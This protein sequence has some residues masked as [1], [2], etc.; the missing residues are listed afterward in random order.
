VTPDRIAAFL[1]T[2]RF[3]RDRTYIPV[4]AMQIRL[5][6]APTI[7]ADGVRSTPRGRK[8]WAVLAYVLLAE[9]PPSRQ[10]L[11]SLLFAEADDPLGALRWTLAE[12][13]RTLRPHAEIEGDPVTIRFASPDTVTVDVLSSLATAAVDAAGADAEV[14]DLPEGE[15]LD[16]I[17]FEGCDAFETWLLVERR[18][19]AATV[20]GAL[21]E[22]ALHLLATGQVAKATAVASRLVSLNPL[23]ENFQEL[24]VRC[25]ATSGQREAAIQQA[26]NCAELFGRELGM[27]PSPAV[28]R[29]AEAG[30]G[31]LSPGPTVGRA[32]ARAQ[33]EAGQAAISAGAVDAGIDCLRRAVAEAERAGDEH[34][35]VDSMLEL[36]GALVHAVRGRDE[37]GAAV[38]H[39]ALESAAE[40][41][42]TAKACRE[43]AFIDV[44]A[45][46]RDLADAWLGR[47]EAAAD[48]DPGQLAS[49]FGVRGMNLLDRA[50]YAEA[51][52]VLG[53]SIE[54]AERAG[55]RRQSAWSR[56]LVARSHHETG[57]ND[58][59]LA[60]IN[61]SLAITQDERWTAFA[62]WAQSI[63]ADI[64][65]TN[66]Q[67]DEARDRYEHAYALACQLG[68]PCWEGVSAKGLAMVEARTGDLTRA[69]SWLDDAYARCTRWPDAYQWVSATV[70]DARCE[71]AIDRHDDAA[72]DLVDQ[73]A[74]LASRTEMRFLVVRSHLHRARLGQPGALEAA[75]IGAA[76]I[77][78]PVL[79][80]LLE[81]HP[82]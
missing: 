30:P 35:R 21:H 68:D 73:L 65:L 13:R 67:V 26:L 55:T 5:L 39:E 19:L 53:A 15:L 22:R 49:I 69:S 77:D 2:R 25:L 24:L 9:R 78:N 17:G 20:E 61:G 42:H 48:G 75:R 57:R 71:L 44:Q 76:A 14:T 59:A 72:G 18:R 12:L 8:S 70:L 58:D 32:A 34:L 60:A 64:D 50:H 29:A 43:L 31:A 80:D 62:P 52:E 82:R 45:G 4:M 46:R 74:E 27:A 54:Q 37:E 56:S 3:T 79:A 81:G 38:L 16:G 7:E 10:R 33:L 51:V 1:L 6:G 41:A 28:R 47:A 66:H 23:D 36:G 63:R 11:A 40:T